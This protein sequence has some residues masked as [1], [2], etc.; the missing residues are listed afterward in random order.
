MGLD[1]L[2]KLDARAAWQSLSMPAL[3]LL[4]E[5]DALVPI[6]VA[7][8]LKQL[9]RPSQSVETFPGCHALAWQY[10]F[11]DQ[12]LLLSRIGDFL[13]PLYV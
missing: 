7:N 12:D 2:A 11:T 6:A 13:E 8:D 1:W 3:L 5:E 10:G 4:A 9:A